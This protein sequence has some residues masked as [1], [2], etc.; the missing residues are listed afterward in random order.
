MANLY[1]ISL[2]P[3]HQV[4]NSVAILYH[5][6]E[7]ENSNVDNSLIKLKRVIDESGFM[8]Q[9]DHTVWF[10]EHGGDY[11]SNPKLFFYAPLNVTCAYLSELFKHYSIE[12]IGKSVSV[13][14]VK[15]AL[16]RL[17][18]FMMKTQNSERLSAVVT[19]SMNEAAVKNKRKLAS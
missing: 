12:Q 8:Q 17:R 11:S 19:A 6:F 9:Q 16:L 5:E 4:M 18:A 1:N 13:G 2:L 15:Q 3:N 10:Y 7:G 14:A